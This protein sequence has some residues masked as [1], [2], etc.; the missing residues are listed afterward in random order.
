MDQVQDRHTCKEV[1][2]AGEPVYLEQKVRVR[3]VTVQLGITL[4]CQIPENGTDDIVQERVEQV[5]RA[6]KD[7]QAFN[8]A[9]E[10]ILLSSAL[11]AL[12]CLEILR[13]TIEAANQAKEDNEDTHLIN[14]FRHEEHAIRDCL[15][16][17]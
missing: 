3:V 9:N 14:E 12:L 10:A 15:P 13:E 5:H 8:D 7:E 17:R 2:E 11:N 4:I 16:F 1:G 6:D